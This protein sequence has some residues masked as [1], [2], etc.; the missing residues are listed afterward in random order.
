[1]DSLRFNAEKAEY[2][3]QL[4]QL[5]VKGIPYIIVADAKITP[6]NNEV[7]IL[8]NAKIGQLKNTV[9]V[10]DTLNGYHRLT[11][12][13]V[14][15][16]SRKEFSGYATYQYVNA[17]NDT[18]NIKMTDF[19][20]EPI[21]PDDGKKKKS[22]VI[23][24]QQTVAN[25]AVTD[26]EKLH[27]APRIF[28]K[29]DMV[30]YA[31]RPALQLKG[32][33]KL[34][35]RKIKNY[36]TWIVYNQSGDEKDIY[37]DFDNSVTEAGR[38]VEAG[39]HFA[40]DN[41]LYITFVFDKK[42]ENDEDFFLAS[43]SL[44]FDKE[45]NEFKIEDRQKAAGQKLS[46][47]VFN[48][49][50]DKRDVRFEG[51]VNFFKPTKDFSLTS[52]ALGNG[53]LETNE[54]KMNA[55]IL[56]DMNIPSAAYQMMAVNLQD[57]IKNEGAG[58]GL[59]DQTELLYKI[60]NLVGEKIAKDYEQKSQQAY[61][62]LSTIPQFGVPI[63]FSNVNLKWSQKQK[64]F[65]N[66][67]AIGISNIGRTDIN[68]GFEGFMEIRKN[69]D[70]SPVFHVFFKAS[71]ESWYYF[72]YEDNRLMVHSSN[73]LFNDMIAKKTNASKAKV[74]ELVFIPGTDEET[75]A[76]IN[77]YRLTYYGLEAPY[78]LA[79]GTSAQKKEPAKKE[80]KKKEDDGF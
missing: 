80:E 18:F 27:I 24:A 14:D 49:N 74:G 28:Y 52:S 44:F 9:I 50:E 10:L 32:F 21:A 38:K 62:S 6:E 76:W 78:E 59:G 43:G 40:T 48:Y 37:L 11:Q 36:D 51:P 61:T 16:V 69:E 70:G 26:Q 53:N 25:G 45:S 56:A 2:D 20:L 17:A 3:I 47:K 31:T 41:S 77:K 55:L 63:V 39:L 33:V 12:G 72:G 35:L 13:V 65:Y 30:M 60:A 73:Q 29:G 5:K 57:V 15:I 34:D 79:S 46:G 54:I 22:K 7:L 1:M 42:D 71:P 58:E 67:G 19:H 23:A 64:A 8:E 68:G 75:L 66:E 4:Q